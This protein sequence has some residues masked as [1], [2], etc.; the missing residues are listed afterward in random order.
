MQCR[1]SE[2]LD[3]LS[4]DKTVNKLLTKCVF[5]FTKASQADMSANVIP[6]VNTFDK[7]D[8]RAKSSFESLAQQMISNSGEISA[9][10]DAFNS[11]LNQ[12]LSLSLL[13]NAGS[14]SSA[15]SS[16]VIQGTTSIL[17]DSVSALAKLANT[18]A[19][20]SDLVIQDLPR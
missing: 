13:L 18:D 1:Y 19:I 16:I 7:Y 8:T 11:L 12:T 17:L 6:L 10:L 5:H 4:C 14:K 2:I 20:S 3:S 9:Q 15:V